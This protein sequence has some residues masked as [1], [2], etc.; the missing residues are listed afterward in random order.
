MDGSE[1]GFEEEDTAFVELDAPEEGE[2]YARTVAS[3]PAVPSRGAAQ[4]AET[5]AEFE[6]SVWWPAWKTVLT[7]GTRSAQN[8]NN[9]EAERDRARRK[10][11]T[12]THNQCL[13]VYYAHA[14]CR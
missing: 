2:D 1:S 14:T 12:T 13:T 5:E 3:R 7:A 9:K 4:E 6:D 8:V 10:V 11:L